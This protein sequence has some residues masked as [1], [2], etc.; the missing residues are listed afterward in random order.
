MGGHCWLPKRKGKMMNRVGKV[1]FSR[2]HQLQLLTNCFISLNSYV[3][4]TV[5]LYYPAAGGN[6]LKLWIRKILWTYCSHTPRTCNYNGTN[7]RRGRAKTFVKVRIYSI[8]NINH[9]HFSLLM[10]RFVRT[11]ALSWW[12]T[13]ILLLIVSTQVCNTNEQS[14]CDV[15]LFYEQRI[16]F[17]W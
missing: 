11:A 5:Y 14:N 10:E 12:E 2:V 1:S 7:E 15:Y 8:K 13:G 6:V 9:I 3:Q 17:I 4:H 16:R